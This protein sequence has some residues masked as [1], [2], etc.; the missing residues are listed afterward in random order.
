ME[1]LILK[2]SGAEIK[3]FGK[4]PGKVDIPGTGDVVFTKGAAR[5]IDIGPDHFLAVATIVTN[6]VGDTQKPGPEIVSVVGKEVTLTRT[7]V[8][9]DSNDIKEEIDGKRVIAYGSV[10][11]QLDMIYWDGK[12]GTTVWADHIATVKAAN[13]KP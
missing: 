12:N 9:K 13:P 7:A 8:E 6:D 3:R 5:P 4:S 2:S 10:G 11:N 1:L